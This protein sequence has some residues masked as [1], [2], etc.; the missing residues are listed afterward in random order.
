VRVGRWMGKWCAVKSF[1][2]EIYTQDCTAGETVIDVQGQ[3]TAFEREKSIMM[4]L[5]DL[6]HPNIIQC[7]GTSSFEIYL[8]LYPMNLGTYL[9]QTKKIS[10]ETIHSWM[11]QLLSALEFV[12]NHHIYHNDVSL[13]NILIVPCT[14]R[15]V[16]ADWGL[17][18]YLPNLVDTYLIEHDRQQDALNLRRV[19]IR[20]LTHCES[21]TMARMMYDTEFTLDVCPHTPDG[22]RREAILHD[23]QA[24][25]FVSNMFSETFTID[26]LAQDPWM[27][28]D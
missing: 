12:H 8:E 4:R 2:I 27:K 9:N 1:D 25:S 21:E 16:L 3:K 18:R 10:M 11:K 28:G 22:Q 14:N 23:P 17:S 19:F 26:E 20:L 6:P 15:I 13:T 5:Q 24:R 7:Y